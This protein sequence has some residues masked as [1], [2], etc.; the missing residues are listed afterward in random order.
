MPIRDKFLRKPETSDDLYLLA[1]RTVFWIVCFGVVLYAV[2]AVWPFFKGVA[3]ILTPFILG[4]ILAYVVHPV[5]A[6]FERRFR[7]GR[8]MGVFTVAG[9]FFFGLVAFLAVLA[10]IVYVQ[11]ISAADSIRESIYRLDAKD[12]WRFVPEDV[13]AK[14]ENFLEKE[15]AV[16]DLFRIAG[17]DDATTEPLASP[18][19]PLEVASGP[20]PPVAPSPDPAVAPDRTTETVVLPVSGGEAGAA[21]AVPA[22]GPPTPTPTPAT[23]LVAPVA[24]PVEAL[25]LDALPAS[26]LPASLPDAIPGIDWLVPL[27]DWV[28]RSLQT[29]LG[30]FGRIGGFF[31]T[32]SL[33]L[34]STFYFLMEMSKIP[35]VIRRMLPEGGRERAWDILLKM[36]D[37]VGGFIRGQLLSSIGVGMLVTAVLLV[38]GPRKYALLIGFV[39]GATNFIPYLGPIMG[40]LPVIL[41]ALFTG[42]LDTWG[43]RGAQLGLTAL[44]FWFVQ[45]VDGFVFQPFIVGKHAA[46]HPLAVMLALVVGAQ[47]GLGGML[48]AV[49]AACCA[50]VLFVELYWNRTRDGEE[51]ASDLSGDAPGEADA[52]RPGVPATSAPAASVAAAS[53]GASNGKKKNRKP[54]G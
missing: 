30:L 1:M 20:V 41:W 48:V 11:A 8:L 39:A 40:G 13:R 46:L 14:A 53:G 31:M 52:A 6:W 17:L 3:G 37:G 21:P 33:T 45:A 38:I 2:R 5:V 54:R 15:G 44:G 51:N 27:A 29:V 25:P 9:L 26:A 16:G 35:G 32:A 47:F 50:K 12:L 43:E 7:L 49:P 18:L 28:A 10:P 4:L 24:A 23:L 34:I 22:P 36:N 19:P 42:T